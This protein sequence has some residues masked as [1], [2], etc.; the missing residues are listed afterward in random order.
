MLAESENIKLQEFAFDA[1]Y[2]WEFHHVM[3]KTAKGEKNSSDL[4]KYFEKSLLNFP[5][6]TIHI[7]FTSN[8]DENSWNG[9][10][11]ERLGDGAKA[12]AVLSF[13]VPGMPLLYNGQE[14]G[15]NKRLEFFD[16]DQIIWKDNNNFEEFYTK[17]IALRKRNSALYAAKKGA[18]MERILTP[19]QPAVY[20]FARANE[21]DK[22][23]A[24]FNFSANSAT[25]DLN[26]NIQIG[27]YTN[28]FTGQEVGFRA[29]ETITLEPWG[30]LVFEAKK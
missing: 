20:A 19:N 18:P 30:Y 11:F 15:F 22:I 7:Q 16:K 3:N 6:N 8:H 14:V 24:V 9:T 5:P 12:F 1:E 27:K 4:D 29:S 28:V 25:F 17:L 21:N 2:G 10:E 23:V 13:M 26:S